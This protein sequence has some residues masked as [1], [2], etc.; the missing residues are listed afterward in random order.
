MQT[1]E[2]LCVCLGQVEGCVYCWEQR[3]RAIWQVKQSPR[4]LPPL[5]ATGQEAYRTGSLQVLSVPQALPE[6]DRQRQVGLAGVLP[7]ALPPQGPAG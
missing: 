4:S 3:L 7:S 1:Q 2:V 6:K 5:P